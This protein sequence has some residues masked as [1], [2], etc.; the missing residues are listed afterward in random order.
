MIE[1]GP[2]GTG[3]KKHEK[4]E[5]ISYLVFKHKCKPMTTKTGMQNITRYFDQLYIPTIGYISV[6]QT[7]NVTYK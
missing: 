6:K 3:K 2:E 1:D 4:V 7:D 5:V